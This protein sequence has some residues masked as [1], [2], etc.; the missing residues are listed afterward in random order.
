MKYAV[1][2]GFD[3]VELHAA[4]GHLIHNF[5]SSYTNR[6]TDEYGGSVENR[7]RFV[8]E[9]VDISIKHFN[10]CRVGVKLSPT[11]RAKDNYDP[12]PMETYPLLL[13]ELDK[14]KIGFI[15]LKEST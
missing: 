6:R 9:L 3:G 15:E 1:Q 10:S 11:S 5:I 4:N 14:R 13:Q 8:L 12:T 7:I 2:A